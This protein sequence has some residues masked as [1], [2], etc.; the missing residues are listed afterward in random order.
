VYHLR[1]W[2]WPERTEDLCGSNL[3]K[4]PQYVVELIEAAVVDLQHAAVLRRLESGG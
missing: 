1:K 2:Q 3:L 4:S